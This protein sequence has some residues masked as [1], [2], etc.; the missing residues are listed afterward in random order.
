M[1]SGIYA[2]FNHSF[3]SVTKSKRNLSPFMHN[4]AVPGYEFTYCTI[5]DIEGESW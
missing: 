5:V 2:V 3:L 1:A 4:I